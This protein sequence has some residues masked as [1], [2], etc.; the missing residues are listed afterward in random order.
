MK[1]PTFHEGVDPLKA[2]AWVLVIEKLFEVFPCLKAQKVR[3]A[4]FTLEDEARRKVA[5]FEGLKQGNLTVAKYE[6]KFTKLT[7]FTPHMVD[8]D[9]KKARK[10]ECGL[11]NDIQ[12]RVNLLNLPTYVDVLDQTLMPE[13]N[14]ANRSK[15]RTDWKSKRHGFF[16]KKGSSKKQNTGSS[17]TSSSSRDAAPT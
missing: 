11:R 2:K 16:S 12:E 14:M 4:T 9:N 13:T 7:K 15:Q 1:Q 8:I 17:T 5:E 3:L 6:A 10:F